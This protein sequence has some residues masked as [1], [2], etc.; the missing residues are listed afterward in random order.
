MNWDR[1]E[2]SRRWARSLFWVAGFAI[3]LAALTFI[4]PP[5]VTPMFWREPTIEGLPASHIA[6]A[7]GIG[8]VIFGLAWMWRIYKAP[9]KYED[10]AIWRY[11]ERD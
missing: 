7:I 8:G 1:I 11:R 4:V 9:A 5:V 6:M 10:R 2:S 3:M